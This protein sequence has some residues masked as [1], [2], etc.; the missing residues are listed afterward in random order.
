M[1]PRNFTQFFDYADKQF[2]AEEFIGYVVLADTADEFQDLL[3]G[4]IYHG[5]FTACEYALSHHDYEQYKDDADF[6]ELVHQS[7]YQLNYHLQQPD[8]AVQNPD[9]FLTDSLI[10]SKDYLM[11][12]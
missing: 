8:A 7:L 10:R 11:A 12:K 4:C 5:N 3:S 9:A 1:A 6:Q 2:T